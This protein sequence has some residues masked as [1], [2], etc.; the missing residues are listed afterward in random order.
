MFREEGPQAFYKGITPRVARVAPGQAVVFTVYERIK[1]IVRL[2][3]SPS[4]LLSVLTSFLPF[5]ADRNTRRGQERV[6]RVGRSAPLFPPLAIASK[7]SLLPA[8]FTSLF[9]S[10]STAAFWL[11]LLPPSLAIHIYRSVSPSLSRRF[12]QRAKPSKIRSASLPLSIASFRPGS[13]QRW[14]KRLFTTMSS[15]LGPSLL[16]TVRRRL[17]RGFPTLISR[18]RDL[19]DGS[20]EKLTG[21]RRSFVNPLTAL[22]AYRHSTR[23]R[24]H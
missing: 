16:S 4:S 24:N 8:V 2:F 14:S 10:L 7:I 5:R 6:H 21:C 9:R 3:S 15:P 19:V 13:A 18:Q 1:R 11:Y 17:S 12:R 22:L 20:L 23:S